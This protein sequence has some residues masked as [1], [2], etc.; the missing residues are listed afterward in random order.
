[1]LMA[2]QHV[3]LGLM[4]RGWMPPSQVAAE[5]DATHYLGASARGAAWHDEHGVIV[6]AA[7]TSRRLPR[8]WLELVRWC[9]MGAPNAGSKQWAAVVPELLK[10]YPDATTVVSYS[11]PSAGHTGALYRACGWEWAPT[12]HRLRPP[13][14]GNGSWSDGE[15]QSVKDR[16]VYLLR[17]DSD[18]ERI[19]SVHDDS[20]M[21]GLEL[22]SFREPRW[23]KGRPVQNC[24]RMRAWRECM[25]RSA[26][27]ATT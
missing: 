21:R 17:A 4:W 5:L 18:R 11:D 25:D 13:P 1:M 10:V 12:W 15:S 16:W 19:L 2:P 22:A 26:R 14:T 23:R 8:S 3:Q 27:K 24:A 9:L 6:F 20:A 7:P